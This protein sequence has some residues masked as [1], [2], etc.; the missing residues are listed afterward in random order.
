MIKVG[1]RAHD[2]GKYSLEEFSNLLSTIKD[3]D[4]QCI[5]LALG[6][7]FTDFKVSKEALNMKLSSY[8][9]C[10]LERENIKLSV[11]GCYINMG[12]PDKDKRDQEIEKFIYHLDFSNNFP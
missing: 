9:K 12:N 1:I 5:Q 7:S 2:M 11:L 6:K 8:L 10:D 3:L 4:G